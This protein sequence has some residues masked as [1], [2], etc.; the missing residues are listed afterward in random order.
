VA[1]LGN[2]DTAG[3]RS[4]MTASGFAVRDREQ[5]LSSL[6]RRLGSTADVPVPGHDG[7][8]AWRAWMA[9][10]RRAGAADASCRSAAHAA[11]WAQLG[12]KIAVF[13]HRYARKLAEEQA[14]WRR[15]VRRAA[16]LP[17]S[18]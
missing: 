2:E 17:D 11:G 12:P 18:S 15:L 3:Y 1:V 14:G 7:D 8:A 13:E 4:C 16:T 10:E 6:Q 5:L 9:L